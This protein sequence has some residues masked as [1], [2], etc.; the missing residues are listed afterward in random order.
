MGDKGEKGEMGEVSEA[1]ESAT[2]EGRKKTTLFHR[3]V[4][5]LFKPSSSSSSSSS[6][7]NEGGSGSGSGSCVPIAD[8]LNAVIASPEA[9]RR[10]LSAMSGKGKTDPDTDHDADPWVS[11]GHGGVGGS[12]ALCSVRPRDGKRI[13]VAVTLN[14]LSFNS[15]TTSGRVVSHIYDK[16]QTPVPDY[17]K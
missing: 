13:S 11:F 9:I 7:T 4:R 16:L 15:A 1:G 10:V 3:T 14:R 6:S 8:Q 17:F 5:S 2:P 12:V